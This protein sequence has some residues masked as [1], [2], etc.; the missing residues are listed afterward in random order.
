[1]KKIT[2]TIKGFEINYV[3]I[4]TNTMSMERKTVFSDTAI[5][6]SA[7]NKQVK[8]SGKLAA[9][10]EIKAY[11]NGMREMSVLDFY[12]YGE[13]IDK[14]SDIKGR[15]ITKEMKIRRADCVVAKKRLT[16]GEWNIATE[17][18]IMI[19]GEFN[20]A[21]YNVHGMYQILEIGEWSD[22]Q[23][24]LIGMSESEFIDRSDIVLK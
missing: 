21:D 16:T 8:E 24:V 3:E 2:R 12:I 13:I 19:D 14:K 5:T 11:N 22:E 6:E 9:D 1:M 15:S 20:T 23:S 17:E 7:F 18:R 4:D 10:I